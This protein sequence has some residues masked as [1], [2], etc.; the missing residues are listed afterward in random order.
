L[1]IERRKVLHERAAAAM[2]SLYV[3]RLD[4][5]LRDLAHHYRRSDNLTKAVEYLGRAGQQATQRSAYAEGISS[6]S[7]AI[8]LLQ[9]LPDNPERIQQELLIQLAVGPALIAVK[10]QSAPETGRAY[11]RAGAL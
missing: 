10:G 8:D 9:R 5:H 7:A 1:L 4:D 3:E 11:A 6:L 2:E